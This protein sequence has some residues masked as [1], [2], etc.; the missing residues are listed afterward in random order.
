[1]L[2]WLR[3]NNKLVEELKAKNKLLEIQGKLIQSDMKAISL[4]FVELDPEKVYY[5]YVKEE[6]NPN[7]LIEIMKRSLNFLNWTP[8]RLVFGNRNMKL[9]KDVNKK[10]KR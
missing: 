7:E 4:K 10:P 3:R 9:Y 1:M 5:V 8:P 2:S 6:D